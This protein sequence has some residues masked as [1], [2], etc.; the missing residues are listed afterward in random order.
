M[1]SPDALT[2]R[3]DPRA[4]LAGAT[5]LA[6]DV[7]ERDLAEAWARMAWSLLA[8]PGDAIAGAFIRACGAWEALCIL[9]SGLVPGGGSSGNRRALEDGFARWRVRLDAGMVARA[10]ERARRTGLRLLTPES[11]FWPAPL[12]DLGPHA[13]HAL[14]A[15]GD[16]RRAIG[17]R[18]AALVGARAATSYGEHVA[19]ELAAELAGDGVV[20]VSGAAYGIDG[21]AHRAALAADGVTVAVL[22]GGADNPYP[23]GHAELIERIG[24]TG[25][26]LAEV[27]P[28]TT[29]TKWRFLARNRVIAALAQ[30][31]VVVEAG[32]RSGAIN[33]AAHAASLGRPLGAVPGAITSASSAGCHR[34]LRD[35]D[36][37][38]VTGSA[39][40]RELLGIE[41]PAL[42][43]GTAV[44]RTPAEHVRVLDALSTRACRT[45][46]DVAHRSGMSE[47]EASGH[48]GMLDL[49]GRAERHDGGWR[50]TRS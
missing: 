50:R 20:V 13:P 23:S 21:A 16:V 10:L 38:C 26:V 6:G 32:W 2:A 4:D 27:G 11:A 40:V 35:Y 5:W 43:D 8:E 34:L 30:A 17:R 47:A 29:P 3:A 7:C 9:E 22:A 19:G 33:T 28:G 31:T 1:S 41:P 18:S 39:D 49:E 48:L 36:A 42:D 24:R 14:W 44:R 15:K 45:T 25:A 37:V 12:E 46:A